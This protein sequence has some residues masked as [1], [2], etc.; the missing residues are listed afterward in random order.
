MGA[1]KSKEEVIIAQAGNS[2][3]QTNEGQV[4]SGVGIKEVLEIILAILVLAAIC[5]YFWNQCRKN[6]K[7]RIRRELA[8]SQEQI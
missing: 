1:S 3:G 4:K 2:G 6:L 5:M 7:K 8:R